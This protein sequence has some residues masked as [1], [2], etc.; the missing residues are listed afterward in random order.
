LL[1]QFKP[2]NV[3]FFLNMFVELLGITNITCRC[4]YSQWLW[5]WEL[6]CKRL[7]DGVIKAQTNVQTMR[8]KLFD[9]HRIM[10]SKTKIRTVSAQDSTAALADSIVMCSMGHRC[11]DN[12]MCDKKHSVHAIMKSLT[13]MVSEIWLDGL[14]SLVMFSTRCVHLILF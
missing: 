9:L 14:V 11:R 4:H 7:I 2:F 8:L 3:V 10:D 1:V 5:T 12:Y 13:N 6:N